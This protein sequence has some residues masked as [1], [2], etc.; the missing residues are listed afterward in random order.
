MPSPATVWLLVLTALAGC[1]EDRVS[2]YLRQAQ[3][4]NDDWLTRLDTLN[5]STGTAEQQANS[6]EEQFTIRRDGFGQQADLF[7]HVG[8]SLRGLRPP[9]EAIDVHRAYLDALTTAADL[10][11][12][13][14]RRMDEV[15]DRSV[16]VRVLTA[17]E[18]QE[19]FDRLAQAI[20]RLQ[21]LADRLS[22]SIRFRLPPGY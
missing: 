1:G 9:P 10:Y 21:E 4:L 18:L 6:Y 20:A 5:G 22:L 17:P 12:E 15:E 13:A 11:G 14:I 3:A 2:T 7:R 19:V 16:F 8:D